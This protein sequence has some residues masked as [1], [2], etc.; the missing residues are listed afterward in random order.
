MGMASAESFL[1]I[2]GV[3]LVVVGL[4]L[5]LLPF[6]LGALPKA[7]ALEKL[8]PYLVYIYRK[9]NF[10]FATS[11]ILILLSLAYFVYLYLR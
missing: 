9:G 10:Y 5:V 1:T 6:A 8:P 4:V 7:E 11:P 2:S 3:L